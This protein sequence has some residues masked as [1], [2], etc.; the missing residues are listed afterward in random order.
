MRSVYTKGN[1]YEEHLRLT[2]PYALW[3][4]NSSNGG[5]LEREK[6]IQM[7]D[8]LVCDKGQLHGKSDL[9]AITVAGTLCTASVRKV[10]SAQKAA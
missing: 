2:D 1:K 9:N 6:E 3:L 8:E 5:R 10:S 7:H 4:I